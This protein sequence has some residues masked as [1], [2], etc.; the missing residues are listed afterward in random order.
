WNMAH[1]SSGTSR[2][3]IPTMND[4]LPNYPNE[5]TSYTHADGRE[6]NWHNLM[7]Q[8]GAGTPFGDPQALTGWLVS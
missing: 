2:S 8:Y 7:I 1:N 3:T 6:P 5:M 4:S